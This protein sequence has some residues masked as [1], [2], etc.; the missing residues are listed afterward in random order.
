MAEHGPV[1]GGDAAARGLCG[2]GLV[3]PFSADSVD[4]ALLGAPALVAAAIAV[5]AIAVAALVARRYANRHEPPGRVATALGRAALGASRR[6]MWFEAK[7]VEASVDGLA[8]LARRAS[9]VA[10]WLDR[11]AVDGAVGAVGASLSA[12]SLVVRAAQTGRFQNYAL[13]IVLGVVALLV[14]LE[15]GAIS[16]LVAR[17]AGGGR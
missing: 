11:H 15:W 6:A 12:G 17:L 3:A 4:V 9:L 14:A 2:L 5:A 7:A 1:S 8:R 13:A 16:G 10:A